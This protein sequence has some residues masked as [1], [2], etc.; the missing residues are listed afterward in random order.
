MLD[1]NM[2][3]RF[4]KFISCFS[5][6]EVYAVG[7]SDYGRLGFPAENN[8]NLSDRSAVSEPHLV[9]GLLRGRR[10]SWVGAGESCSYAVDDAGKSD[11]GTPFF[12]RSGQG[13]F[14]KQGSTLL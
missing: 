5:Q 3:Y 8:S 13:T 1:R 2:S 14:V 9:Q 10:C 6:G 7:R 4:I 11:C 12:T